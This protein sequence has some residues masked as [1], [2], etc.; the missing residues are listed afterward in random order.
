MAFSE[1]IRLKVQRA[2]HFHC[3]LCRDLGVEVHHIL[4]QAESGPDD[5]DNAAPLCPSCHE[6]YGA[7]PSK[8]KFIREA[9]DLWYEICA[10]R[11]AGDQTSLDEIRSRLDSMATKE[12]LQSLIIRAQ[13]GPQAV[14]WDALKYSFTRD[15]F[16]HPLIVRELI[17]WI[18]DPGAT[19]VAVDIG[20]ANRSNRFYGSYSVRTETN[21]SPTVVWKGAEEVLEHLRK[22]GEWF[23]YRLVS[24][25]SSGVHMVHCRNCT[26]GTGVFGTMA[27]LT[28]ERDNC[29]RSAADDSLSVDN[30]I[31]LKMLGVVYLR[32]RYA[33]E[34]TYRDGKLTIGPDTGLFRDRPGS[35]VTRT[36]HVQ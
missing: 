10:S 29:L 30:R 13:G 32:D 24:V 26:G 5:F 18:S 31:I 6:T 14:P 15:E 9:R 35:E 17:G 1:S 27:L 19:I 23:S 11:Y 22:E 4:P 34:I 28:F 3:C 36:I 33:G 7:N 25:S 12:D 16:V 8:R 20:H 2:A 21:G